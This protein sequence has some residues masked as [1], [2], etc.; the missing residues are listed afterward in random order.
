MLQDRVE[1]AEASCPDSG[2]VRDSRD[3]SP[4]ELEEVVNGV[5]N[6]GLKMQ[7]GAPLPKHWGHVVGHLLGGH[8]SSGVHLM[9]SSP[10]G[11]TI[12]LV[13]VTIG[14]LVHPQSPT[15][16]LIHLSHNG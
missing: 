10:S 5:G 16:V 14:F 6:G 4:N 15:W 2:L 8:I 7:V 11:L 1:E 12:P 9:V 13:K 3:G